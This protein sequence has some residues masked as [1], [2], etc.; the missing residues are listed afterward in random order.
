MSN[1]KALIEAIEKKFKKKEFDKF[2]HEINFPKFKS[3]APGLKLEIKFPVTVVVGPNGGGKSSILHAAWGMPLRSSTSR[4]WF[5]TPVDPIEFDASNQHRYWYSHYIKE[6]DQIVQCRKMCGNKRNGYWEP[7]RPAI[8]ESM[9]AMPKSTADNSVFMSPSGDRW[10][11]VKRTPHYINSK[12]ESSA[13]ERYFYSVGHSTLE[14][15]QDSFVKYSRQLK[16]AIDKNLQTLTY[17][18]IERLKSNFK[19]SQTQLDAINR[20]LGKKYKSARYIN[21]NLYDKN[22]SPSVI[23]ETEQRSYSECFAGSGELAVVNYVLSLAKLSNYDLLLLDEP[24]TSLH[25]GAQMKLL[26]YILSIVKEKLIQVI[27]STHSPTFVEALPVEA[28]IVLE[29]TPEGILAR[30]EPSKSSAFYRLGHIDNDKITIIT[31]DRLLEA[32][33]IR[34]ASYMPPELRKKLAI[35]GAEVGA[36]EMLSNQVRAYAQTGDKILMLLDGDQSEIQKIYDLDP[37]DLSESSIKAHIAFLKNQKV[38]IVGTHQDLTL[39]MQWCKNHVVL[40]DQVCPEQIFLE[41]LDPAHPYLK[42]T[43]TTNSDFKSAVRDVLYKNGNDRSSESQAT[44]FKFLLGQVLPGDAVE[45]KVKHLSHKLL[46]RI[47]AMEST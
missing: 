40:L 25:P 42:K 18:G 28:L 41:L 10:I 32:L 29:D 19:I 12:A 44:L 26:E 37:A 47:K 33:A 27:I 4:F 34:A 14:A 11:Q 30:K 7:T 46:I 31:E 21:H 23:F 15:K 5:S 6:I 3:F 43:N 38:S 20:I 22:F 35:F 36:S 13:F 17:Y 39:W 9:S 16:R 1:I 2:I 8:Q 45:I 24:E